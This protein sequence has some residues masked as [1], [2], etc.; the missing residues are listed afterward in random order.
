[1]MRQLD[2]SS[3]QTRFILASCLAL[4][5]TASINIVAMLGMHKSAN[6]TTE[7]AEQ[8]LPSVQGISQIGG[9]IKIYR[10]VE[11]EF[12]AS[13]LP[14]RRAA[15][16]SRFDDLSG[17]L[18]IYGKTFSGLIQDPETQSSYDQF[19]DLWSK[20]T[21]I[22]DRMVTFANGQKTTEAKQLLDKEGGTL[23]T[24][25]LDKVQELDDLSYKGSIRAKEKAA[26]TVSQSKIITYVTLPLALAF[27]FVVIWFLSRQTALRLVD[28]ATRLQERSGLIS[29]RGVSLSSLA[30]RLSESTIEQA[31]ALEESS[32]TLRN[33]NDQVSSSAKLSAQTAEAIELTRS[34]ASEG[35]KTLSSLLK[36]I[37]EI[38]SSNRSTLEHV[39]GNNER[40][41]ELANIMR[42]IAEKTTVINDIVFQTK[43]L[44]FNAS[45]EAARAGEH[46]KGFAVVAEEI[47]TL[48]QLSGQAAKEINSILE[49]SSNKV[50]IITDSTRQNISESV[51]EVSEKISVGEE[52]SNQCATALNQILA[53]ADS[54]SLL[55]HKISDSARDQASSLQQVTMAF[56]QMGSA[57]NINS[58]LASD[59]AL[60]S[61][62][63]LDY[64]SDLNLI[65]NSLEG[66]VHGTKRDNHSG[67]Q[68]AH[69]A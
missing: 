17:E 43:L 65:V 27:S 67:N 68:S 18:F 34:T 24:S 60:G 36:A 32:T 19:N 14:E 62:E 46:G 9:K 13:D 11:W 22:H 64:G 57:T 29:S 56:D 59:T 5:I 54:A 6:M 40:M 23:F 28:L 20:Y 38:S 44:S 25:I 26:Q 47:A 63:I 39:Q 1:M 3:L 31:S 2:Q 48:A 30:S 12:L 61:K 10:A 45:V 15:L 55:A 51:Y 35:Q 33:I 37:E 52:L 21:E 7:I 8:W 16:A 53:A 58:D 42:L 41:M 4:A 49:N 69:A 66:E 50:K